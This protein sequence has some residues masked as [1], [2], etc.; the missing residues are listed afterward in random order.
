MRMTYDD[1][2]SDFNP[3]PTLL[4]ATR[5][6]VDAARDVVTEAGGLAGAM[7]EGE[8]RELLAELLGYVADAASIAADMAEYSA[9]LVRYEAALAKYAFDHRGHQLG[10]ASPEQSVTMEG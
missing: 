10:E 9:A 2:E 5:L 4:Q 3:E 7:A 8:T 1:S 6:A